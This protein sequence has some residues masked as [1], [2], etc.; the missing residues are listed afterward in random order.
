VQNWAWTGD[1][2]GRRTHAAAAV[3]G[4]PPIFG[5]PVILATVSRYRRI[6]LQKIADQLMAC[7]PCYIVVEGVLKIFGGRLLRKRGR[8]FRVFGTGFSAPNASLDKAYFL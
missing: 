4:V 3:V 8:L 7:V 5:L 1:V 2:A 6:G